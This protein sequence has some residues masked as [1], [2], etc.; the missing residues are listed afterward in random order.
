MGDIRRCLSSLA[1]PMSKL[2]EILEHRFRGELDGHAFGNLLITA[3]ADRMGFTPAID[4]VTRLVEAQAR[5]RPVTE[6]PVVLVADTDAGPVRGQV[7]VQQCSDI[8]RVALEPVDAAPA[9]DVVA[10]IGD[11]EWAR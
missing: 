2:G 4:E 11:A 1:D 10:A 3:L 8:K 9:R 6:S 5:I 7:A